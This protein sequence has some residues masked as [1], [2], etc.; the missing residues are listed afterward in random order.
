MASKKKKQAQQAP[1]K[2]KQT[3]QKSQD[4]AETLRL[5]SALAAKYKP[6]RI[7]GEGANGV[8]WLANTVTKEMVAIKALHLAAAENWKSLALFKREAEVLESLQV[9]GVPRFYESYLGENGE[10]FLVQQYIQA[11]SL[12]AVAKDKGKFTEKETLEILYSVAQILRVLHQDYA[13]PIIHRDIKPSNILYEHNYLTNKPRV[14]LIDFGAVA[15]PQKS[16]GGSTIAGT[17][18]YMAPEQLLGKCS[19]ASDFY[20]L[21]ATAFQMLTG[22]EPY[23]LTS[24]IFTLDYEKTLTKHAPNTSDNMREL[25]SILL[26]PKEEDR[27]KNATELCEMIV[28]VLTNN[29]PRSYTLAV[30]KKSWF[31]RLLERMFPP[32]E[33]KVNAT[34]IT[35]PG[36][37]RHSSSQY[38]EYTFYTQEGEFLCGADNSYPNK[39]PEELRTLLKQKTQTTQAV[40]CEVRYHPDRPMFNALVRI[41]DDK[42]SENLDLF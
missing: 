42:F 7:I 39:I 24:N 1:K 29:P 3:Q 36:I 31:S 22:I 8:T 37:I 4:N 25:L 9:D 35:V 12:Q 20:A 38:I 5:P 13:P 6:I 34:W 41:C 19:I 18:G 14:W 30:R 10:C 28:A 16:G 40:P 15:N 23:T 2:Q 32:K 27:P 26:A 33:I 21:G 17:S 11:P